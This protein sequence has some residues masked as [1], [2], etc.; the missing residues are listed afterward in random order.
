MYKTLDILVFAFMLTFFFATSLTGEEVIIPPLIDW[1]NPETIDPLV[2]GIGD[3]LDVDVSGYLIEARDA[4]DKGDYKKAAR[5][6]LLVVRHDIGDSTSIYNLACCY[7]LMGETERATLFLKRAVKAGF[8]DLE[9]IE[10][11]KDF[12]TIRETPAFRA[13]ISNLAEI[14]KSK[15]EELGKL[16][17]IESSALFNCR[18]QL[19]EN[20]NPDQKY[21]LVL[22]LHGYG[23][24]PEGFIKLWQRFK[25][26]D[27]IFASP[28]APY[29]F[30]VGKRIGYS[31]ITRKKDD[32]LIENRTT[33]LTEE[34]VARIVKNLRDKY[35][36]NKIYL[37]GF[38]QGCAVAYKAG[39]KNHKLFAGLICFGGWL[40]VDYLD[41][42]AFKKAKRLRVF[43]AHGSKDRVI[44]P[45]EGQKASNFLSKYGFDVTFHEFDGA[46]RV[47]GEVLQI[48]QSWMGKNRTSETRYLEDNY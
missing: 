26:P 12:D 23:S 13:A 29:P 14:V 32:E 46:H 15:T 21:D 45:E 24:N 27:F 37:L 10:K 44:K 25:N 36:L 43:I 38:S 41:D 3:F 7:G 28:Q 8:N 30:P 16:V 9:H 1:S 33:A 48:A 34:Y 20:F 47:P 2:P 42:R 31:W 19:P 18:V 11:D 39:I 35:R 6:Y 4:Y 40:D 22:G 5:Y 17:N